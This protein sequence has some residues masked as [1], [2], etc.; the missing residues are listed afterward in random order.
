MT[1]GSGADPSDAHDHRLPLDQRVPPCAAQNSDPTLAVGY[2]QN[3]YNASSEDRT[4]FAILLCGSTFE[5]YLGA[6]DYKQSVNGSSYGDGK[7][8][9]L[10]R[11]AVSPVTR[12]PQRQP[13]TVRMFS[14][15]SRWRD[16]RAVV[17][18]LE[19]TLLR[20]ALLRQQGTL[21]VTM[22]V[23]NAGD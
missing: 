17:R 2:P 23:C 1:G 4:V 14:V 16:P 20:V 3:P 22:G 9:Y 11:T 18:H 12:G 6:F 8:T 19:G 7:L 15:C 13:A 21:T 5:Q 10:R